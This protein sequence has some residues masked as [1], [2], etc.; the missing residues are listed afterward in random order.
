MRRYRDM[1]Q[2]GSD[3]NLHFTGHVPSTEVPR[4]LKAADILLMP[5]TSKSTGHSIDYASP[6]K[7][8]DYLAA[9]KPIIASDFAVLR[10]VFTHEHN[11][12]LVSADSERELARGLQWVLDNPGRAGNM[13]K[14]A[15]TDS[16]QYTW[17][18]RADAY[19]SFVREVVWKKS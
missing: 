1:A 4:Y 18:Q 10:E 7:V 8:F 19:L 11:A 13:A 14:Q 15:R 3:A 17:E 9:G 2:E 5:N 16:K 6:M 12:F